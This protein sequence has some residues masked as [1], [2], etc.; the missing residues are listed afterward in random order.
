MNVLAGLNK[1]AVVCSLIVAGSVMLSAAALI[2][3]NVLHDQNQFANE[4]AWRSQDVAERG[5]ARLNP[6]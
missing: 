5:D 6:N 1:T 2:T 3:Y 4:M